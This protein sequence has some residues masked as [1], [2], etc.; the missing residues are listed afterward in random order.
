MPLGRSRFQT[1]RREL[2]RAHGALNL[3]PLVD[4]LTAIV[5]FSLVSA[6]SL[7]SALAS[8]DLVAPPASGD[9]SGGPNATAPRPQVVV[10]VDRHQ[11]AVRHAERESVI[12]RLPQGDATA[13][14]RLRETL[15]SLVAAHGRPTAVTVVPSDEVSYDDVVRVLEQVEEVKPDAVSLGA[16]ARAPRD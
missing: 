13:F 3:V 9:A 2:A 12:S 6:V 7:R 4:I 1:R 14:A 8:F 10:R 11:F 5:F 15:S 16:R